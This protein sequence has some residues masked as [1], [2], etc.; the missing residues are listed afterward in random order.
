MSDDNTQEPAEPSLASAGSVPALTE[1]ERRGLELMRDLALAQGQG[2]DRYLMVR[3]ACSILARLAVVAIVTLL[4]PDRPVAMARDNMF[5]PLFEPLTEWQQKEEQR[6]NRERWLQSQR[7]VVAPIMVTTTGDVEELRDEVR[8]LRMEL[9]KLR[10]EMR[11][12]RK[13]K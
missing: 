7:I 5:P 3:A 13:R 1:G 2:E 4:A 10:A 12:M 8:E 9:A 6:L 11:E